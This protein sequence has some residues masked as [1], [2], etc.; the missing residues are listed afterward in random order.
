MKVQEKTPATPGQDDS[1]LWQV[2]QATEQAQAYD[3]PYPPPARQCYICRRRA[4]RWNNESQ[5]Y[6]CGSGD[7]A[8]AEREQDII[9]RPWRY[10]AFWK[11]RPWL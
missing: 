11:S 9:A 10:Y 7:P 5:R 4:W 2:E 3:G 1:G 6:E 8:H